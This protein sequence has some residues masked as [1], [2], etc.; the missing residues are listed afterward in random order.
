MQ[1][2]DRARAATERSVARDLQRYLREL[3]AAPGEHVTVSRPID[4][5]AFE[6]TALLEH[7]DRRQEYPA[8]LFE[9]PRN[10]HGAASDFPLVSNLFATRARCAEALGLPAA[11]PGLELS[12]GFAELERGSLEPAVVPHGEAPVQENVLQ[13]KDADL[14]ILPVVRHYEMDL[15]PVL[16]MAH[17]MRAPA[18]GFYDVSFCKTFPEGPRRAGVSIHTPHLGRL[19]QE[20]EAR[21]ERIPIVNILGHHPAFWL[22]ALALAPYGVDDYATIGSFLREP[23]RLVPS[24]TW[25]SDFLVPADAEI[26]IEGELI[27][28]ERTVVDPF[29]EVTRQYQAQCLRPVMEV[30]AIIHRSGAIMQDIFSGHR[31]HWNLGAIPKEG[32]VYNHLARRFGNVTGICLPYSGCGRLACYV[33]IRKTGEGEPKAVAL[34]ALAQSW[35]FQT[36]VVVDDD[37]DVF[38]EEDVLWAVHTF[39]DPSRDVDL[40]K[41]LG[42]SLFTT[43][44]NQGKLLIDAT[45]PTHIAFPS[46]FRVPPDAMQR[47][48]LEEW[49]D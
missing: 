6:V 4:P 20:W 25:G 36:V 33:S 23:L 11:R 17:V 44:M 13:G 30:Q 24:V 15:G 1:T 2:R 45:R 39:V 10:L 35:T 43:A 48:R 8:V 21:G 28:G 42:S 5:A 16:T 32:S 40:I 34:E 29:G 26:I 19:L 14:E 47:M 41:N 3:R 27:P 12:L 22:G 31:E 38:N 18:G 37:I 46:R 49:I 7:L 9:Q